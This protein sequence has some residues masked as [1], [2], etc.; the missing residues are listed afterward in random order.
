MMKKLNVCAAP[1][2]NSGVSTWNVMLDVAIALIPAAVM[3]V[4][5]FGL[6]ALWIILTCVVSAVASEF[7]FNLITRKKQTVGDCSALVTG[8]LLA[9]NLSTNVELWQCV[10]GSVFAI[11]I[12]K[13][14]F[15][16]LGK[17]I[18][19]PAITARVFMLLTFASVAGGAAISPLFDLSGLGNKVV[20]EIAAGATPLTY[21]NGGVEAAKDAPTLL[22]LLFGAHGGT[23]GETCAIALVLGFIYLVARKVIKWYVPTAFVATVFVLYFVFGGFDA[24]FALQHVLAGG[25]L[26][27]AIFMATDYVTTPVTNKGRVIF[28]VGCGILT[29]VIRQFCSF[30][31]GVSIS[32][33]VM[34][35]LV[36]FIELITAPKTLGG[37]K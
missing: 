28:A 27:G 7:L 36:P 30:P 16:G 24:V 23:I 18:V 37:V 34:N 26:L 33:L 4:V 11:V 19:N 8:L 20:P 13:C 35:L 31:E 3:A 14:L 17:N 6:K 1:H 21:L 22:Q 2:I 15:G 29:F 25:V 12:V 10:I 5:L 32:I 9:L